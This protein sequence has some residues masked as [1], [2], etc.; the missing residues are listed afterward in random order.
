[1]EAA[2]RSCESRNPP[3]PLLAVRAALL[4]EIRARTAE[5]D[6]GDTLPN[7]FVMRL[8]RMPS[9][10]AFQP[11]FLIHDAFHIGNLRAD[12]FGFFVHQGFNRHV[13]WPQP[14][15][16]SSAFGVAS[17]AAR[18]TSNDD[19]IPR[20]YPPVSL[21]LETRVLVAKSFNSQREA[22]HLR[23]AVSAGR[24]CPA[25]A[26]EPRRPPS[27]GGPRTQRPEF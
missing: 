26:Q 16:V 20:L 5:N 18:A 2:C 21:F 25:P 22:D 19:K 12:E 4:P 13:F 11:A 3:V 14:G 27:H 6:V 10:L 9:A 24:G 23:P 15:S 8:D 1:M 17:C 7:C